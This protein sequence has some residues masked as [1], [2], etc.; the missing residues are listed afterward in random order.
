[1]SAGKPNF[2]K[3]FEMG[4]LPKEQRFNVPVLAQLDKADIRLEEIKKGCCDD[5]RAKFFPNE[6][7][8]EKK[9]TVE[10]SVDKGTTPEA[11]KDPQDPAGVEVKCEV[12]GC[13][14]VAKGK[15]EA[16]AKN[17]LRLHSRSHPAK[18]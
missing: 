8:A 16:I 13:D 17:N 18:E 5:C 10:N 3:L 4:K 14:F 11:P 1:M 2:Q 9:E 15:S 6:K 7:V 12:D